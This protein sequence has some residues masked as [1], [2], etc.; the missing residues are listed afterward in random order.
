MDILRSLNQ[1]ILPGARVPRVD[2]WEALKKY[3]MP[4]DSEGIFLDTDD[5]KDYI[6]MKS[7]DI[8]GSETCARYKFELDPV[9][10]FDPD[11]YV[12]VRDFNEFREEIR[13]GFDSI[14]D[15]IANANTDSKQ[16]ARHDV[17]D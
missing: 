2:G 7:V 10:E 14:K 17:H 3:P 12:T 9:E 11:K 15:S 13:H 8:N 5:T 16:S 4:R 6:Y 1:A